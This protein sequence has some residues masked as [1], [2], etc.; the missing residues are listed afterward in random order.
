MTTITGLSPLLEDASVW[1]DLLGSSRAAFLGCGDSLAAA[2]PAENLGHRVLSA[3]DV[4]WGGN[5]PSGVDV[6]IAL[7]WSGRTGATIRAAEVVKASG[8][9]VWAI[10]SNPD[11]PLAQLADRHLQIPNE[12]R[13]E[14]IPVWGFALHSLAVLAVLGIP[15]DL[16][17]VL[18]TADI[19]SALLDSSALPAAAPHAITVTSLPDSHATAEFWSLKLIEATGIAAR[20][21]PLEEIGHVDYFIGPQPHLV[22]IPLIDSGRERAER[23]GEAL[24]RNGN[25]VLTF[26]LANHAPALTAH[27]FALAL[28]LA[29][30]AFAHKVAKTWRRPPFRGGQVDMS[31]R[32]IQVPSSS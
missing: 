26:D 9:P 17:R 27:E 25:T 28:S 4:A 29:G 23:L 18:E 5:G 10:T 1:A 7:S 6:S 22:L 14:E 11:S 3:G 32:H 15:A 30:G 16:P 20:L 12:T 21:A 19:L 31:A 24:A 8:Q 2:R 13:D